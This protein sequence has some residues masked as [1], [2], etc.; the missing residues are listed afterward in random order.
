MRPVRLD[1]VMLLDYGMSKRMPKTPSDGVLCICHARQRRFATTGGYALDASDAIASDKHSVVK[2][3]H[4]WT[5]VPRNEVKN[6]A[7]CGD[8]RPR[9]RLEGK[10]LFARFQRREIGPTK[11]SAGRRAGVR[12]D[13]L[14]PSVTRNSV[15]CRMAYDCRDYN[16]GGSVAILRG[17]LGKACAI[18][19]DDRAWRRAMNE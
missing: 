16:G 3:I 2:V 11:Y 10:V 9:S 5:D 12:R 4:S 8:R 19:I 6:L 15:C 7:Y 14:M 1:A 18:A 13:R 17:Q